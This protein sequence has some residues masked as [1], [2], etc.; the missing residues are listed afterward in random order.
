MKVKIVVFQ[1]EKRLF[2]LHHVPFKETR[3]NTKIR[4]M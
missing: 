1:K 2:P 3:S 4:G